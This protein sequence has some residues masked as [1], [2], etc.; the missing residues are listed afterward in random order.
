[1]VSTTQSSKL[2]SRK[3]Q[4]A[5]HPKSKSERVTQFLF[6]DLARV[7]TLVTLFA[8]VWMIGSYYSTA[9]FYVLALLCA[10]MVLVWMEFGSVRRSLLGVWPTMLPV[11][12]LML[13]GLFQLIQ[14]PRAMSFG[15][16]GVEM[17]RHTYGSEAISDW[18]FPFTLVPWA[19]QTWLAM[20]MIGVAGLLLGMLLFQSRRSRMA[21]LTTIAVCGAAQVFWGVIQRVNRPHEIFWNTPNP[22]GSNPFGTFLN[23]NHAADFLGMA[24]FC[25]I[26]LAWYLDRKLIQSSSKEY[27]ISGALQ[28][29]I[30][31]PQLIASW[32]LVLWISCGLLLT[33][34][35]GA[36]LSFT[37]ASIAIPVCWRRRNQKRQPTR[38]FLI[39]IAAIASISA[40]QF[41]GF[42]D[43]INREVESLQWNE[44]MQDSRWDHWFEALPAAMEYI[45]FGSGVGTYGYAYLPFEPTP[46]AGWF[47]YAHNQYLELFMETG[48]VGL[49]FLGLFLFAAFSAVIHLCQ[50]D[51]SLEKQAIGISALGVLAMTSIHA[52]T[53]FGLMMPANLLAFAVLVGAALH[54]SSD[55]NRLSQWKPNAKKTVAASAPHSNR[56]ATACSW[57]IPVLVSAGLL[58]AMWH[59]S[60]CVHADRLLASTRFAPSNPSPN[61]STT[62]E[63]IEQLKSEL[64]QSPHNEPL[65]RRLIQLLFHQAQRAT[66]DQIRSGQVENLPAASPVADWDNTSLELIIT[67]LYQTD[68]P[69]EQRKQIQQVIRQEPSLQE[70]W[71]QLHISLADNPLQARTQ[72]RT[73]LLACASGLDWQKPFEYS[74]RLAVVDPDLSLGNGLLAWAAGDVDSM[75]SQ[76]RRTLA[77]DTSHLDLIYRLSR[78]RLSDQ[79][80]V[81]CLMPES[82]VV[83]YRLARIVAKEPSA[84]AF[85]DQL[86]DK[87][88][89]IAIENLAEGVPR[90]SAE[91]MIASAK[92]DFES[93]L[94]SFSQAVQTD[95]KDPEL[96]YQYAL[97]LYRAENGEQAVNEARIA[98]HLSPE[99]EKYRRFFNQAKRLHHNQSLK[100][101]LTPSLTAQE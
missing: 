38:I 31:S 43:A 35:R 14:I 55:R 91:G 85:H 36:W 87:A 74:T 13:Y 101:N 46:A 33:F 75:T 26:G 80:V 22:A 83:P 99:S 19:T 94:N 76:W 1:M 93:A 20:A 50:S 60:R 15:I 18:T 30:S 51:R 59:Q 89:Q 25:A 7:I 47:L 82:W 71:Q 79:D 92:G 34:S 95:P 100:Q 86:L 37:L 65:R 61:L 40:V 97:V 21:L 4:G 5:S 6:L 88:H 8:S 16:G 96:R 48:V 12:G 56:L 2:R 81:D 3:S 10:A 98:M 17:L 69:Q 63:W 41:A 70:A 11:L 24:L 29:I 57:V 44:I 23:Q 66:Y 78:L 45:P 27:Q 54:A 68:L 28:R 49:M 64:E 73:A 58:A 77:N 53:D 62:A 9:R 42:G 52:F 72:L 39:A 90:D 67:S 84:D 32:L